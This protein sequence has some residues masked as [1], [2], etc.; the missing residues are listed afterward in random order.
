MTDEKRMSFDEFIV[1]DEKT[2][3]VM[4]PPEM[5]VSESQLHEQIL[6]AISKYRLP[7]ICEKVL[8]QQPQVFQIK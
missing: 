5:D 2:I 1:L 4:F 3:P 7:V 6:E 8:I